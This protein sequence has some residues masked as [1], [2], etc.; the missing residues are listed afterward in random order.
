MYPNTVNQNW[1]EDVECVNQHGL[2]AIAGELARL[3]R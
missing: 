1:Y 2:M 3:R